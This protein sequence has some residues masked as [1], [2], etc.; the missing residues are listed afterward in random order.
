M[1]CSYASKPGFSSWLLAGIYDKEAK[2]EKQGREGKPAAGVGQRD[3]V[4]K[5]AQGKPA[6]VNQTTA[7]LEALRRNA[8]ERAQTKHQNA[9]RTRGRVAP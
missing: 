4:A 2:A 1:L 8:H 5:C 9:R 3:V 6:A 7:Y